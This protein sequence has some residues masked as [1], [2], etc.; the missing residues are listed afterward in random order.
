MFGETI[1]GY[2]ENITKHN[3]ESVPAFRKY[4]VCTLKIGM[5]TIGKEAPVIIIN[6]HSFINGST[7]L[8]WPLASSSV[9]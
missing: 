2:C 4:V 3:S 8:C 1:D 9:S 6:I 5:F 7:A